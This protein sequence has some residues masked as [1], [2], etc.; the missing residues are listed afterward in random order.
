MSLYAEYLKEREDFE[1]I[2]SED[3]FIVYRIYGTQIFIRDLYVKV[4][5]RNQGEG[6]RLAHLLVEIGKRE[7][8]TSLATSVCPTAGGSTVSLKAILAYGFELQRSTENLIF[9]QKKI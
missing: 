9:L 3:G 5:K 6:T 1:T 7:G 8:C 4:E 2:E